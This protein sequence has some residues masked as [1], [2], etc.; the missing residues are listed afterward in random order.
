MEIAIYD[1]AIYLLK[2][3]M[4]SIHNSSD[5]LQKL[6]SLLGLNIMKS[7]NLEQKMKYIL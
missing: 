7:T 2:V 3:S 4:M 5:S 6:K 1:F